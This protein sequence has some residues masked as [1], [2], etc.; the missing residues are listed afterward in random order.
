MAYSQFLQYMARK[1]QINVG[2]RYM[3]GEMLVCRC[4]LEGLDRWLTHDGHERILPSINIL[5]ERLLGIRNEIDVMHYDGRLMHFL[6]FRIITSIADLK[7]NIQQAYA[8]AY[9]ADQAYENNDYLSASGYIHSCHSSIRNA[10]TTILIT[11]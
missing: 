6:N 11:R 3:G 5:L 2:P 10:L 9:A 1:H 8:C 7:G 4:V